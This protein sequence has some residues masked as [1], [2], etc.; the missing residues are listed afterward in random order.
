MGI[1]KRQ[2]ANAAFLAGAVA[3]VST[4]SNAAIDVTA[5]TTTIS[6]DGTAAITAVGLALIGLAGVSLVFRWVKAAFF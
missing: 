3:L 4:A 6:G 5:A 1:Q 2:A